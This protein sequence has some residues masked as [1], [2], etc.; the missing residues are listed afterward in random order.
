MRTGLSPSEA[1]VLTLMLPTVPN[2]PAHVYVCP[3][4]FQKAG[5]V[6]SSFF[7]SC[8]IRGVWLPGGTYSGN[9][10]LED[11]SG[12]IWDQHLQKGRE[13]EGG[14]RR[15]GEAGERRKQDWERGEVHL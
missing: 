8:S 6:S 12:H 15:G 13:G 9:T 2:N 1:L 14:R 11:L 5:A 3:V 7:I 4:S 10:E